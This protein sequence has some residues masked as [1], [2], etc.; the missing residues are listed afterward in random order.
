[1]NINYTWRKADKSE[2]IENFLNEKL[3]KLEKHADHVSQIHVVFETHG[4]QEHSI[5]ITAHLAGAEINAHSSE[6][7][8]YKAI[9]A[10]VHKLIHQ[11]EKHKSKITDHRHHHHD[12]DHDH[13]HEE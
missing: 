7:D 2:V 1:M 9:D 3:N 4:K 8:F 12:C 11:V 10:V 6:E 13:G 5:K